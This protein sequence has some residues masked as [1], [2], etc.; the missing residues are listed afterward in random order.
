MK[1]FNYD[2]KNDII[3]LHQGFSQDEKFK[4]NIDAGDLILDIS[5][6]ER[7]RGVEILNA[8]EFLKEFLDDLSSV[9]DADF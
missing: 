4:C 9:T 7:V 6:K 2:K 1:H 5:T 3:A 8:S